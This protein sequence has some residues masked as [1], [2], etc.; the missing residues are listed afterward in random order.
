M[1]PATETQYII[2]HKQ[3]TGHLLPVFSQIQHRLR[4]ESSVFADSFLFFLSKELPEGRG[5]NNVR[6]SEHLLAASRR[7]TDNKYLDSNAEPVKFI[8]R[9]GKLPKRMKC[10]R[11]ILF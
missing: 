9:N 2:L 8:S 5:K 1:P 7:W 4:D 10:I 11:I 3:I 6:V